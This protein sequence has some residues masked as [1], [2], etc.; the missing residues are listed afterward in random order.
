[1]SESVTGTENTKGKDKLS[2]SF[3]HPKEN[4]KKEEKWMIFHTWNGVGDLK[5]EA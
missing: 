2:S 3:S 4:G 1:M 5:K